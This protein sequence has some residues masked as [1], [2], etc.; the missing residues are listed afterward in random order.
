M[1]YEVV[2]VPSLHKDSIGI[3]AKERSGLLEKKKHIHL[4]NNWGDIS[5]LYELENVLFCMLFGLLTRK[6]K[7]ECRVSVGTRKMAASR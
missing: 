2:G 4:E 3:Q 6:Y 7:R 1:A 5:L